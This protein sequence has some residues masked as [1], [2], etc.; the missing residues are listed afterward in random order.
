VMLHCIEVI[1]VKQPKVFILENVRN[2]KTIHEGK[3]YKY[4]IQSLEKLGMYNVY[5]DTYDTK[6]YGIPQQR[7]RV[8]IV[9]ILKSHEIKPFVTP[10][11]KPMQDIE[12]FFL[13]KSV[14]KM[15]FSPTAKEGLKAKTG[16]DFD[17]LPK[18]A[19]VNRNK[20]YHVTYGHTGTCTTTK[21]CYIVKYKRYATAKEY[22]L[23]QGFP[24]TFKCVVSNTQLIR[25]AGNAMSV[26]VVQAILAFVLKS[27]QL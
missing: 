19:I 4:L 25:Q 10:S 14:G 9:G 26:N 15:T 22:L 20:F 17:K 12:G 23:L 24:K 5:A 13:T 18:D 3:P 27:V 16:L 7:S 8:Y 2:F 21:L 6:D 11:H 1:R